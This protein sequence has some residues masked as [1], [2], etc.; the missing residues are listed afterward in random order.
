MSHLH[1]TFKCTQETL[2]ATTPLD[3]P[4]SASEEHGPFTEQGFLKHILS[5][6]KVFCKP[7][8]QV[9][10]LLA[11]P[12]EQRRLGTAAREPRDGGGVGSPE[13]GLISYSELEMCLL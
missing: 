4:G 5:S 2:A 8:N 10:S 9:T 1:L 11:V 12:S 6:H 3:G 13:S 7:R